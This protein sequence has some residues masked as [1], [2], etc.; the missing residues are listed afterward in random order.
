MPVIVV[1]RFIELYCSVGPC[2]RVMRSVATKLLGLDVGEKR[3]GIAVSDELGVA[4]HPLK[5]LA[6]K[7][8]EHDIGALV[9]VIK[10]KSIEKII[11][12]FPRN[13]D[14]SV[15]EQGK[16]VLKFVEDL[17]RDVEVPVELWDERLTTAESERVLIAANV[18]RRKRKKVIDKL[19][20]SLILQGYLDSLS[21]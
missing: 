8:L 18:S 1:A 6:R 13:M 17:K 4:A 7:D 20:A 3:I 15:G 2:A 16:K 9:E 11:V 5:T 21:P 12:G 19:A 14:G 10:E